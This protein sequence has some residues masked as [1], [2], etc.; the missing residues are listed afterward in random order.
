MV[1]KLWILGSLAMGAAAAINPASVPEIGQQNRYRAAPRGSLLSVVPVDGADF[2]TSQRFDI[3]IE[4][5]ALNTAVPPSLSSLSATINGVPMETYFNTKF[6]KAD[7]WNFTYYEDTKKRDQKAKTQVGV[8]RVALRQVKM[9]KAGECKVVVTAGKERVTAT[10]KVRGYNNRKAK[11]VVLFIGDGMAPTMISAARYISK[12]TT[13]GKF[14]DNFLA[15]ERLG[16]I[17]KI[18]T[19]GIDAIITDSANSASAYNTGHKSWVNAMGVYADTS[20]DTLDDPKVETIAEIIRRERPGMCIGIVTTAAVQDATPAAVFAHTR[21]RSDMGVITDQMINP[22]THNNASWLPRPLHADVFLGGGGASFCNS[23]TKYCESLNKQDYYALYQK[24]G[25]EVVYNREQLNA[26]QGT[27]P[28]LGIFHLNHMDTWVER[29]LYKENVMLRESDPK[30]N[31]GSAKDQPSLVEMTMKAIQTMDKKCSDGWF[32]MAE[33]AS[34]DKMMHA[35]DFE[36]ALADL[37][38]LDR[39]IEA[40][41]AHT[42]KH[43]PGQTAII[44]TADHSQGYDV[45]GSVDTVY[46]NELANDDEKVLAGKAG[47]NDQQ[48]RLQVQK[49]LAIND[50]EQAGWPDLVIDDQTG[51]PTKLEGRYKLAG[52]KVDAPPHRENYQ[53]RHVPDAKTNPL[54]RLPSITDSLLTNL[55]GY[56]VANV[57]PAEPAGLDR[58][59]NLPPG[60]SST[61]HTLQAVDIYCGG[62]ENWRVHC[63]K[64]M[65]NTEVF[66]L[67]AD[68]L[69]LGRS[70]Q[71]Q[72]P[73]PTYRRPHA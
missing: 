23:T 42:A 28:L 30:G 62:P 3:S 11:N 59:P 4:L 20:P 29:E 65:D 31:G 51:L 13:F 69:G 40:V 45:Y 15:M 19:N 26:Y 39:T 24:A 52:G 73:K 38:E 2:L 17:G 54:S 18:A 10:W 41:Q 53:I 32:L 33:A 6:E 22:I 7:T 48:R 72:Y 21:R 14:G 8:T 44:A 36:R 61:V 5:H 27:K 43:Y 12:K 50:Y 55:F 71:I 67:M 68:A 66:F 1:S 60:D 9:G 58:S 70:R 37:L 35:I 56:S 57:N 34:V 25:Y 49:R 64:A 46:F 47:V 16:S 63:G